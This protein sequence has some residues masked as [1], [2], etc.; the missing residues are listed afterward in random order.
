LTR[1]FAPAPAP[2]AEFTSCLCVQI[3]K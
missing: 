2:A 3:S 1:N